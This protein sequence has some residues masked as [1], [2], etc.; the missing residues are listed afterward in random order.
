M[1]IIRGGGTNELLSS[2]VLKPGEVLS[3]T[4][5][6]DQTILNYFGTF[7]EQTPDV[8]GC[9]VVPADDTI[10][11]NLTIN[12]KNALHLAACIGAREP[13]GDKPFHNVLVRNC[14]LNGMSDTI[15]IRH[16]LA[17]G[18][19]IENC[20]LT[21]KWDLVM[22]ANALH[23]VTLVGCKMY[24]NS[25]NYVF[26][27]APYQSANC[28][29][30]EGGRLVLDQCDLYAQGPTDARGLWTLG[31]GYTGYVPGSSITARLCRIRG[32]QL[33]ET[34]PG[35]T[36]TW[37]GCRFFKDTRDSSTPTKEDWRS[38]PY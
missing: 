19:R 15:F 12:C 22:L 17:C 36:I 31:S 1:P 37:E 2:I 21:T 33:V 16:A 38:A 26:G 30:V 34:A 9:A 14:I 4:G 6:P 24:P 8:P 32:K 28:T 10:I 25:Y 13:D 20:I 11:E 3:G 23:D 5:T 29:T 35:S 18:I 7:D 27:G